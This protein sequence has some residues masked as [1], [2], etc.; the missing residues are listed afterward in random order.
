MTRL[1]VT[2]APGT[3]KTSV[4]GR[5]T[6]IP[7]V[8]EPARQ[9]LAEYRADRGADA[10]PPP[11]DVFVHLLLQ[12]SIENYEAS[13]P[14]DGP[15]LFDR[16]VP[17]CVAYAEWLGTDPAPAEAAGHRYRYHPEVLLFRPWEAIY[18]TDA[19]RT[20][21]YAMVQGFHEVHVEVYRRLG[22]TM[23]DVPEAGIAARA[24]FVESWVAGVVAGG[25]GS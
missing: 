11:H 8:A 14:V 4:L 1:I 25:S 24:G 17:D 21:T 10:G 18:A 20:M 7:T 23:I 13:A 3:G 2:G 22:Y 15:V 6:A 5:V 12:R 16:G 9:V 19:E